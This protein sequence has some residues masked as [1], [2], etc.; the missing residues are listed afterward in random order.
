MKLDAIVIGAHP[1]DA[2]ISLGG[3]I[4]RLIRAGRRVGIIDATRGELGTR[5]D[6]AT[7]DAE[8]AAANDVLGIAV[9]HNLE[10]PDG[11]VE[12]TLEARERLAGLLRE[13]APD[14]VLAHHIDDLHP[15][16]AATGLLARQ[17]WYLAGL[18]RLAELAG[19]APA[20]RPKRLLHFMGHVPFDPTFV[21]D[22]SEV[23]EDKVR[24]ISCYASQ[25]TPEGSSDDG[26][27]F[28]FGADIVRRAESAARRYG[29]L[30][31]AE[32]GEPLLAR[33]PVPFGDPLLSFG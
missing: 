8:T 24:L 6:K 18:K 32:Y 16:H 10:L 12:A 27:H 25:I 21:V 20:R 28:L 5:G 14:L 7:R 29:E 4:L 11:R 30:I 2:E 13:H 17:A 3:T 19:G 31:G 15:D 26:R 23:W 22:I 33:G 1:D 9:R